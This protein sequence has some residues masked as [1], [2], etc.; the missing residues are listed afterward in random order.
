MPTEIERKFLVQDET[1]RGHVVRSCHYK[2][3]YMSSN[4]ACSIR[5]RIEADRAFLNI[6]SATLGITRKEYDYEIPISDASEILESLCEKPLLEKT[7]Y[8]VEHGAHTWEIDE[9]SGDNEGLV[10]AEVEL[11]DPDEKP[12]LPDWIGREVSDD[13]RYYNVCLIKNPYTAWAV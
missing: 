11:D 2:Q 8:F 9:F 13:P 4:Q 3:G 10:V 1:W 12:E 6:K 5:V 7:R